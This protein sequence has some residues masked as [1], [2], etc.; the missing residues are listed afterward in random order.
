M[1]K[2]AFRNPSLSANTQSF[3]YAPTNRLS[4]A[5][6][7]YGG[8]GWSYD[9][10]GNRASET[11]TPPGGSAVTDSYT[12]LAA[13][14]RIQSILRDAATTRAFTYDAAGNTLTDT[15]LGTVYGYAYNGA[16]RLKTVS[17]DGTLKAT[18]AYTAREQLATRTLSN[19][20]SLDGTTY[21]VHDLG[22]NIIAE[23]N[24]SGTT[25]REYIWLAA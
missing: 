12:Y 6:G 4:T 23:L 7:A 16:N 8:L 9:G 24:A 5:N 20:G 14:N 11:Q 18:Y 13:S 10:V 2:G 19:S 1:N 21:F 17:V 22:G 25:V 3:A 15:R